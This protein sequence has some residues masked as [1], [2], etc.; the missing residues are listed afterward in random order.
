[1]STL[2]QENFMQESCVLTIWTAFMKIDRKN[3]GKK[4]SN[5]LS[6]TLFKDKIR[7]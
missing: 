4:E 6:A 7:P 1:L 5:G 2:T 3:T